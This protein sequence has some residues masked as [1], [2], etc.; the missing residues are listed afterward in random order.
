M[1]N[2]NRFNEK[3]VQV[4]LRYATSQKV[5]GS[6]YDYVIGFLN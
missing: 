5:A 3:S 1:K 2:A 4:L 6:I